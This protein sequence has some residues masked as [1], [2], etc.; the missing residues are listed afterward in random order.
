VLRL[1]HTPVP[2]R[3]DRYT[4]TRAPHPPLPAR[5][6]PAGRLLRW[7]RV[8]LRPYCCA[9][10]AAAL[11]VSPGRAPGRARQGGRQGGSQSARQRACLQRRE[12]AE[13]SDQ[14][15]GRDVEPNPPRRLGLGLG[16]GLG[17]SLVTSSHGVEVAYTIRVGLG[18]GLGLGLRVELNHQLTRGRGRLQG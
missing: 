11:R 13:C 14:V 5:P 6:F 3:S 9:P 4:T 8:L 10:T 7:P 17:L 1:S 15:C 16:L 18:L 12:C 2:P